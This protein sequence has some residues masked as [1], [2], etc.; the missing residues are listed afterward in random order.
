MLP[1]ILM[2]MTG[3]AA[4][5]QDP[6]QYPAQTPAPPP[7]VASSP[8]DE[9]TALSDILVE[10]RSVEA[11]AERFVAEASRPVPGRGLARWRGP[12][13]IGVVNFR[14]DLAEQIADGLARTGGALGVPIADGDC[15]ANILIVGAADAR[16]VASGWVERE[17]R[18]FRPNIARATLSRERLTHFMTADVPVRWWAISRPAY[19][20]V[21]LGRAAPTNGRG[22]AAIS[23]HAYTRKDL[24]IRDDLQR[25]VV[26]LDV[27]KLGTVGFDDL[28]AYLTMVSFAQIDM[29]ADMDGFDTVLN[30][31]DDGYSGAGLTRWD[32]AYIRSLYDAPRDLRIEAEDQPRLLIGRLQ[33]AADAP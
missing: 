24:H 29:T 31:F 12:V 2:L 22:S 13:C 9:P 23:V 30:L 1:L 18:E 6:A 16:E 11:Q 17:Y 5:A 14:R 26:I 4:L 20:D 27:E 15:D 32:Q 8:Q 10:G 33:D 25:I 28:V 7:A 3:P 21:V 19:F